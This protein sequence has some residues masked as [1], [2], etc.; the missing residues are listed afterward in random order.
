[1]DHET[2]IRT[3][4]GEA[5]GA[6]AA[7][8]RW[9]FL[10]LSA[11]YFFVWAVREIAFALHLLPSARVKSRVI[12]VGNI[13]VGGTGKTPAVIYFARRHQSAGK[14][15]VVISRGYGRRLKSK[16]PV[17]VSDMEGKVLASPKAS[18]DEPYL[19]ARKLPGVPVIA[20][21]NRTKA[22]KLAIKR[23]NPEMILLDDGF[24]HRR[25]R[26]DEDIVVIDCDNP[27]GY[28]HLLPRGLL[29]EPLRAL[30]RATQFLLTHADERKHA[31]LAEELREINPRAGI[32]LSRH[33]AV[34]LFIISKNRSVPLQM[35]KGRSVIALSSIG[36]PASFERTLKKAGARVL[37][38]FRFPDHYWYTNEDVLKMR[39][40]MKKVKPEYVVT[41]EKDAVR[42][43]LL[44]EKLD[45]VV[46]LEIELEIIGDYP[47]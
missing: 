45:N 6:R 25:I 36:N 14:R 5:K 35:L 10:A 16:K 26:R 40:D 44:D 18:G 22:A 13:T 34:G 41:T 11:I 32:L 28:D 33:R 47:V 4:S 24:Q 27:F 2:Y 8:W 20:C 15:V 21:P 46:L 31:W 23:F 42:L 3:I 12:S 43:D 39:K 29:R 7:L 19:L 30:K 17:I 9:F 1:M 38:A 37:G